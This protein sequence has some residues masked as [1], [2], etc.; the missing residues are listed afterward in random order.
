MGRGAQNGILAAILAQQDFDTGIDPIGYWG[1]LVSPTVNM[2]SLVDEL[3]VKWELLENTFKPYPCGIV[4]HPLI[5]GCLAFRNKGIQS[6]N[7]DRLE[8]IVNPQCMRLCFIQHP[9]TQLEAIFSLYHGC[10]VALIYGRGGL[11][12]FSDEVCK[13]N[14]VASIRSKINVVTDDTVRDDEAYLQLFL[15]DGKAYEEHVGHARGS[16]VNPLTQT[17]LERKFIDQAEDRMG[18][19]KCTTIMKICWKLDEL[20]GISELLQLCS[21]S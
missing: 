10:A 6:D 2:N 18:L 8:V 13:S 7:I 5:D 20:K 11:K 12:E 3:G 15:K 17:D 14:A 21:T 16:L 9:K 4:I 19:E 1:K